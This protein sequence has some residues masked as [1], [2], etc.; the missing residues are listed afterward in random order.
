MAVNCTIY[1]LVTDVGRILD[2]AKVIVGENNLS[3]MGAPKAWEYFEYRSDEVS[4]VVNR[5]WKTAAGSDFSDLVNSTY[6]FVKAISSEDEGRQNALLELL[7]SSEQV[8][9]IVVE[10]EFDEAAEE[11]VFMLARCGGG[12]IFTGNEFLNVE[13]GL[14]LDIEGNSEEGI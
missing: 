1:S 13:G 2:T 3:V 5:M 7:A 8:F 4:L 12:V 6:S 11:V 10:P 14:V 9:G